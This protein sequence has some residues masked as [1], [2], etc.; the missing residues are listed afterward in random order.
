MQ[1]ITP[2]LPLLKGGVILTLRLSA[3]AGDSIQLDFLPHGKDSATGVS[4]PPR[5]L[6]GTAAELEAHLDDFLPRYAASVVRVAGFV[7]DAEAQ[8]KALED[9]AAAQAR[10]TV[11]ARRKPKTAGKPAGDA[12]SG[13]EH[14]EDQEDLHEA[15][16]LM[17]TGSSSSSSIRPSP[18]GKGDATTAS[19][20][21]ISH[22]L[23]N[24]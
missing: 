2:F 17:A 11:A 20:G 23:F 3:A 1:L 5:A 10:Q 6:V 4:L 14:D 22:D 19:G 8:L 9:A 24:S 12:A 7:A 18:Q 16:P 15:A 21:G 13:E